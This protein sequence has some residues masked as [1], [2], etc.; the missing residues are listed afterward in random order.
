MYARGMFK[1]Q[2]LRGVVLLNSRVTWVPLPVYYS[3]LK[4]DDTSV[5]KKTAAPPP[6]LLAHSSLAPSSK[7]HIKKIRER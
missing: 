1:R 7:P 3:R 5:L 6:P 4:T 2:V